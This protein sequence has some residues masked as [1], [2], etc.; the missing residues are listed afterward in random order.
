VKRRRPQLQ[1]L[2]FLAGCKQRR[3]LLR[4]PTR[5]FLERADLDVVARELA[6]RRLLALIGSRAVE[7]A[8]DLVSSGFRQAVAEARA[9]ARA[10]GLAVETT[11]TRLVGVL[12]EAGIRTLVLKGPLL[13]TAAHGD[14]GLRETSDVDLLV[15]AGDLQR[16]VGALRKLGFTEPA[17]V[18]RRNGLP[19]LHFELHHRTLPSV[20]LHWRVY[21]YENAFTE[22]LLADAQ[23]GPDGLLRPQPG[24]LMTSLLLFY[25]RD[26]FHGVRIAADIA[27]WW[28]RHGHT[29]SPRFLEGYVARFPELEPALVAAVA[30]TERVT[31]VPA[32]SWLA[33]STQPRRRVA[34]AA[35]LAD[36]AQAGDR[37]QMSANI[38][39]VGALLRPPGTTPE[40]AQRAFVLSGERPTA[41]L[42]H[43]AKVVARYGIALWRVRGSRAWEA[44]P[45]G[46]TDAPSAPSGVQDLERLAQR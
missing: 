11:T 22:Q 10:H 46:A 20:E 16:A 32:T 45:A 30:A 29:L 5:A 40:F 18:V 36:W 8:P 14:L 19:D 15:P 34:T 2:F 1:I 38:S 17:D 12:A 28:D 26:G 39:L 41:T 24:D 9:G 13:A 37:D 33:G 35:R 7:A 27:A 44:T 21:W 42:V 23:A 6:E 4:T 31:G 25:A 43:T 3:A